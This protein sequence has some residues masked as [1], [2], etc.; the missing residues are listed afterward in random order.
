MV[1]AKAP[2][3][4]TTLAVYVTHLTLTSSAF[5]S[6]KEGNS[7]QYRKSFMRKRVRGINMNS[8]GRKEKITDY[9]LSTDAKTSRVFENGYDMFYSQVLANDFLK[10]LDHKYSYFGRTKDIRPE[11]IRL[12]YTS[13]LRLLERASVGDEA[14]R[15]ILDTNQVES[16]NLD[17][18]HSVPYINFDDLIRCMP[19]E[20]NCQPCIA[21]VRAYF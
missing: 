7:E 2:V 21:H 13:F 19:L 10:Y 18:A 16:A 12:L 3:S 14:L 11:T 9:F 4:E 17:L 1:E 6:F 8:G 20:I 5:E 15:A